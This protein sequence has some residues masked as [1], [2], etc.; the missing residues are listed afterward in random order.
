[1]TSMFSID[2]YAYEVP[3][4]AIATRPANPP[5]SARL[6]VY[7]SATDTIVFSTFAEI[8]EF[9]PSGSYIVRNTTKVV[10]AKVHLEKSGEQF[11][12]IVL[13]NEPVT[14]DGLVGI[15]IRGSHSVGDVFS[16][17][18]SKVELVRKGGVSW[19]ARI[20]G[21]NSKDELVQFLEKTGETPLPPYIAKRT[22]LSEP[23]ASKLYQSV[24]AKESASVA[25]PTA[26][27]HFTD[28]IVSSLEENGVNF[29]D[30][31]LHVGRGT[32]APV[33]ASMIEENKL[34][35]EEYDVP[36]KTAE[37]IAIAKHEGRKVIA[38][39][40]TVAR[41]LESYAK[42]GKTHDWTSLFIHPAYEF[43]NVNALITNF[44]VP[45]SSLLALVDAFLQFKGAKR[46]VL[47][48]YEIALK[49]NFKFFSF[50]DGMLIL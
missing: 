43:K 39:G 25:A 5:D 12:A 24:F 40:T 13:A 38:L 41:T 10:H 2:T 34:H 1:M 11:E 35:L 6:F 32:F 4:N 18:N 28:R 9:I 3:E 21:V 36:Q 44:H 45:K 23:E 8:A 47:D 31:T 50:G 14:D 19:L 16:L 27:L 17:A 48:L 20:E 7:N 15:M 29:L 33:T 42:T 26:S 49:E 30:V 46:F 37:E 22:D